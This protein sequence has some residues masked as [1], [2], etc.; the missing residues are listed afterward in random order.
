MRSG[1]LSRLKG[2]NGDL[3]KQ[4]EQ[5]QTPQFSD[6]FATSQTADQS[7]PSK[8]NSIDVTTPQQAPAKP[9][10]PWKESLW[11][12]AVKVYSFKEIEDICLSLQ[13]EY[14]AN[15]DMILWCCWL[16]AE[17]IKLSTSIMDEVL[18]NIDSVNQSTLIKLRGIRRTLDSAGVFTEKQ[19]KLIGKQLLN[20][21]L[22]IEKV[23]LFRLQ[24]LTQRY[25]RRARDDENPLDM[26][27]YFDFL[28]I[29]EGHRFADS[30][31]EICR[32]RV[33][34]IELV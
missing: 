14:H 7:A 24:E 25:S 1:F 31:L 18:I 11:D 19:S 32:Q 3:P 17:G 26:H 27:F 6:R 16:D 4:G 20:A 28:S 30:I 2:S 29:K 33:E 10:R 21:E 23:L 12:Y 13:D 8:A 5:E 15:I 34:D 9:K 22:M